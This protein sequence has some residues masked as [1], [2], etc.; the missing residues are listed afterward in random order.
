MDERMPGH[1]S[2]Y[3]LQLGT[4][5][6]WTVLLLVLSWTKRSISLMLSLRLEF[7]DGRRSRLWLCK[8]VKS[9]Q[10]RKPE[11]FS[12]VLNS[13][14][15]QSLSC[16]WIFATPWT[17]ACQASL[18]FTITR[19]LLTLMS[20]E[21]VMPSNHLVLCHPLLL[22]PSIFQSIRVNSSSPV[23]TMGA[24]A[25]PNYFQFSHGLSFDE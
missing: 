17:A 23:F 25:S 11:L 5:P 1:A 9:L 18:S 2:V 13:V 19:N 24:T 7:S 6:W 21:S 4:V 22:L 20:I 15:A 16:V 8:Y 3:H 12:S 14:V 10:E